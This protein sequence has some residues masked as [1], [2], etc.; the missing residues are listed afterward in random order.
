MVQDITK[1]QSNP[2]RLTQKDYHSIWLLVL[3]DSDTVEWPET[4]FGFSFD[5]TGFKGSDMA[6]VTG[7]QTVI[8]KEEVLTLGYGKAEAGVEIHIDSKS[9]SFL[10]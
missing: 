6:T 2:K 10:G 4:E 1:L 8:S 3:K 5:L 9:L 7:N